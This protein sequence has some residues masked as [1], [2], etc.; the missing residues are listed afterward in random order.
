MRPIAYSEDRQ[1]QT[2]VERAGIQTCLSESISDTGFAT[3]QL[4]DRRVGACHGLQELHKYIPYLEALGKHGMSGDESDHQHGERQYTIVKEEWRA[5]ALSRFLR[6]VDLLHLSQKYDGMQ[7]ASRGNWPRFRKHSR[8][9]PVRGK[10]IAGLPENFYD[11]AWLERLND[12]QRKDLDIRPR[13]D[14]I[15]SEDGIRCV[16][17]DTHNLYHNVTTVCSLAARQM[18]IAGR[19]G[20]PLPPDDEALPE[21]MRMLR[22]E[23]TEYDVQGIV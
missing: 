22:G 13:V 7:R 15:V 10:A 8:E 18:R 23:I 19:D 9:A 3:L 2:A 6:I 20:E 4:Y 1:T 17:I 12:M 14:L 5:A 11:S 21:L 16:C